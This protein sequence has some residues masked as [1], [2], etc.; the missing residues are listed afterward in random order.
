MRESIKQKSLIIEHLYTDA[1]GSNIPRINVNESSVTS[2]TPNNLNIIN[3]ERKNINV[4]NNNININNNKQDFDAK[5]SNSA[6]STN[7]TTN[8]KKG[9]VGFFQNIFK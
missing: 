8:K 2:R 1:N 7:A 6:F 4:S 3:K 5:S 9:F